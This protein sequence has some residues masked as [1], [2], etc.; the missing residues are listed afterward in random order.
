MQFAGDGAWWRRSSPDSREEEVQDVVD[1]PGVRGRQDE[2]VEAVGV[3]RDV[4]VRREYHAGVRGAAASS[5]LLVW[6][7][8]LQTKIPRRVREMRT[9]AIGRMEGLV[10]VRGDGAHRK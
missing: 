9:T 1:V 10:G 7:D 6:V 4:L 3:D 5:V 2:A 8:W